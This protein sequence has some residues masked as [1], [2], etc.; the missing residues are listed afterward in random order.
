VKKNLFYLA[1]LIVFILSWW[2]L[3]HRAEQEQILL[4][5]NRHELVFPALDPKNIATIELEF[6][7]QRERLYKKDDSWFLKPWDLP[8]NSLYVDMLIHCMTTLTYGDEIS[9]KVEDHPKY[10]LDARSKLVVLR[11]RGGVE[12]ARVY[13][14]TPGDNYR[15]VFFRLGD[16]PRVFHT[17]TDLFPVTSRKTWLNRSIWR[18]PA[19][20]VDRIELVMNGKIKTITH[21][22]SGFMRDSSELISD[23]FLQ[24]LLQLE[25]G[26]AIVMNPMLKEKEAVGFLT[27]T[28]GPIEMKLILFLKDSHFIAIRPESP[29]HGYLFQR[30]FLNAFFDTP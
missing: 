9:S 27:V 24:P 16:D 11:N 25:A 21:T 2:L 19:S 23:E 28:S 7:G 4:K 22:E 29:R 5:K 30:N 12:A 14:G 26:D 6:P 17:V 1:L 10:Q 15:T 8:A 20:A 18:V 13:I 3:R